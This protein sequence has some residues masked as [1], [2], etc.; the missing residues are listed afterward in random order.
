MRG[1]QRRKYQRVEGAPSGLGVAVGNVAEFC[2]FQQQRE[3]LSQFVGRI[4]MN[5]DDLVLDTLE[6]STILDACEHHDGADADEDE[7]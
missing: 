2:K 6:A 5:A 3:Y 1:K 7:L 4:T